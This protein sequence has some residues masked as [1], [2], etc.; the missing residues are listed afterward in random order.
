[1]TDPLIVVRAAV[2]TCIFCVFVV[3]KYAMQYNRLTG[4]AKRNR[5]PDLNPTLE[6]VCAGTLSTEE[7]DTRTWVS[8]ILLLNLT[9]ESVPT[10]LTV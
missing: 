1:M 10:G 2:R 5:N 3:F 8:R 6:I 4:N 7:E 9:A